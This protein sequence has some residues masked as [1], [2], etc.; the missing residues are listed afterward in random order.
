MRFKIP[1]HIAGWLGPTIISVVGLVII[2]GNP[3][4]QE[5][6]CSETQNCLVT[7]V[8]ALSGWAAALAAATTIGSLVRQATAAQKQ[9]DFQLGDADPTFD[10]VQHGE[11]RTSVVLRIRNWN[12]RSMIIR[13]IRLVTAREV[14]SLYIGFPTKQKPKDVFNAYRDIPDP[15][16]WTFAKG[17]TKKFVPAIMLEGWVRREEEPPL[18]KLSLRG[19][20]EKNA[21][22]R[23]DWRET[24]IEIQY[25]LAGVRKVSRLT[26]H[27]HLASAAIAMEDEFIDEDA[28]ETH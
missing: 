7:W 2:V 14:T 27:V 16:E 4:G 28:D 19:Y 11:Q 5:T 17:G 15:R 13:R 20:W 26:A 23:D 12:R 24:P 10:A 1:D 18:L 21:K 6:F 3:I 22:I 9:A 8:G 25:E